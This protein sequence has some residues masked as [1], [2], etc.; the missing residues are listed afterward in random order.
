VPYS[1]THCGGYCTASS[2]GNGGI[3]G[4]GGS[5]AGGNGGISCGLFID[6]DTTLTETGA[7]TYVGGAHGGAGEGGEPEETWDNDGISGVMSLLAP[8]NSVYDCL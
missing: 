5:G 7:V 3:G 6:D 8:T 2:G 4:T 1:P